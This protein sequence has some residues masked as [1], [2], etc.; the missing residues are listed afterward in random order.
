MK[1]GYVRVSTT[2]QNTARQEVLMEE[3]GV[4]GFMGVQDVENGMK[5]AVA[6][7]DAN[8]NKT[9][10]PVINGTYSLTQI[11]EQYEIDEMERSIEGITVVVSLAAFVSLI[12]TING[13]AY[14]NDEE[15]DEVTMDNIDDHIYYYNGETYDEYVAS[16]VEA[17]SE[18]TV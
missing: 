6:V 5:V 10:K 9:T 11:R 16:F 3:L 7:K 15:V 12:N 13:E 4:G 2:D 17:N 8:G 14:S 18:L 1:V